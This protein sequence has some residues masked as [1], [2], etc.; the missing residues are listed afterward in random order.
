MEVPGRSGLSRQ[1]LYLT[2]HWINVGVGYSAAK[3]PEGVN[4]KRPDTLILL[5]GNRHS[6]TG[7]HGD[8]VLQGRQFNRRRVSVE[9]YSVA[10]SSSRREP[11]TKNSSVRL[12]CPR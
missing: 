6:G 5:Y 11:P 7:T 12:D 2:R 9:G 8:C 1:I 4:T 10:E 3:L